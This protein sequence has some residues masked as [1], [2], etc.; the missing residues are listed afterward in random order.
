M[1]K[2]I[3]SYFKNLAPIRALYIFNHFPKCAGSSLTTAMCAAFENRKNN[4]C[5]SVTGRIEEDNIDSFMDL[6]SK[7]QKNN[8][9]I[10]GFISST[11]IDKLIPN[12]KFPTKLITIFRDPIDRIKSHYSYTCM[13]KNTAPNMDDFKIFIHNKANNN[14][15]CKSILNRSIV[16]NSD[17]E[18]AKSILNEM[19]FSYGTVK[20]I[21]LIITGILSLEGLPNLVIDRVNQTMEEF[22]IKV[23]DKE[24]IN[25]IYQLNLPDIRLFNYISE[26]PKIPTIEFKT[27][28]S[29]LTIIQNSRQDIEGISGSQKLVK[30]LEL[31]NNQTLDPTDNTQ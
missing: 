10:D 20:D 26:T 1:N 23:S 12:I 21:N 7:E 30:T 17:I 16:N 14:I 9:P 28:I 5:N 6:I 22:N 24:I 29:D 19:Y 4:N 11:C 18:E 31:I 3:P 27:H 13:R 15:Y 25:E 2:L 8:V